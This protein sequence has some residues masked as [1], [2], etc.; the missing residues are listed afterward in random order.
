MTTQ[1]LNST[2]SMSVYCSS[3]PTIELIRDIIA[4]LM[5]TIIP[6]ILEA[7]LNTILIYQLM[8]SRVMTNY[9]RS[10]TKE[11]RFALTIIALN[12][13]FLLTQIPLLISIIYNKI[14]NY[15]S[16]NQS[17]LVAIANFAY[18]VSILFASYLFGS[19]FFI[20]LAFNKIFQKEI[21]KIFNAFLKWLSLN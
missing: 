6:V 15:Q 4:Q 11:Y 13:T 21:Q 14:S 7:I 20:N 19:L 10:L 16:L 2:A 5:R 9:R 8:K 17:K 18:L 12:F 1:T 3:T